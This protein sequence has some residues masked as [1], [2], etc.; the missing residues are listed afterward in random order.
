MDAEIRRQ[1]KLDRAEEQDFRR[2]KLPG[3]FMARMLYRWD[4]GKFE[5]EYLKKLERNWR[6][7][8]VVSPEEKP[9]EGGNVKFT[10]SG[11][12]FS[13]FYFSFL[14]FILF[15]FSIFYF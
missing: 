9:E 1:E 14:F 2:G 8:K 6:R 15:Y 7:W 4:N 10:N 5:K 13:L 12:S 3:K 11:L